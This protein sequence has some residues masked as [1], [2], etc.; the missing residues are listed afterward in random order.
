MKLAVEAFAQNQ[1][2]YAMHV[3]IVTASWTFT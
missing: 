1:E 3:K 2:S